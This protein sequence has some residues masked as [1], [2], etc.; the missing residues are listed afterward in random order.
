[1]AKANSNKMA[2]QYQQ[3]RQGVAADIIYFATLAK[4]NGLIQ[5]HYGISSS[6]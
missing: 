2:K 4:N 6:C 1:L 5:Q 3:Q